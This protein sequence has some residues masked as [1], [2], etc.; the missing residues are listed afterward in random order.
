MEND[1]FCFH[2]PILNIYFVSA[3]Y[4]GYIF[5]DSHQIPVPVGH[6]LVGDAR[7]DVEHD[8]GALALD[9]V[10]VAEAAELL[11]TRGVPDVEPDGSSVCVEHQGVHLDSQRR[12]VLLL[13]LARQVSL[14]E[15]GLAGASVSDQHTFE[16][17]HFLFR[18]RYLEENLHYLN[19]FLII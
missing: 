12:D 13:E 19:V 10:A 7:R 6:V 15:R 9:V 1:G 5:T 17:G 2:F 16:C 18:H 8:D 3:Q 11:L 4:D 14:D